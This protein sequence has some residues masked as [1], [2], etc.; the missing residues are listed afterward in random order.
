MELAV[1]VTIFLAIAAAL[2][3]FIEKSVNLM[4]R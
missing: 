4:L 2:G 3:N 1:L